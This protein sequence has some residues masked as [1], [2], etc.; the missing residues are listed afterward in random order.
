MPTTGPDL[1]AQ[2]RPSLVC[3]SSTDTE[4]ARQSRG[5]RDVGFAQDDKCT[6]GR[7]M[8]RSV[9]CRPQGLFFDLRLPRAY[10]CAWKVGRPAG[11]YTYCSSFPS[12]EALGYTRSP[13]RGW[14]VRMGSLALRTAEQVT[15]TQNLVV[16]QF[17]LYSDPVIGMLH[18]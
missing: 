18:G 4:G 15:T 13:L 3:V 5:F 16:S 9:L 11:T 14:L 1:R 6:R 17:Q 2:Y 12:A 7:E 10:M 8:M